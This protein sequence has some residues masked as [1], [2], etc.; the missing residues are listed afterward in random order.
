M[1][2]RSVCC[3]WEIMQCEKSE[4]C[5]TRKN[6]EKPCWE[7]A[8]TQED[9]FRNFFQICRDCI[10]YVL[11]EDNGCLS[12]QDIKNIL[13]NKKRCNQSRKKLVPSSRGAYIFKSAL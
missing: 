13:A 8:C 9:D 6:P 2:S 11:N 1:G 7:T 12:R 4:N 10:V 5:P 3:C